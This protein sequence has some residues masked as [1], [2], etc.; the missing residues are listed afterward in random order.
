VRQNLGIAYGGGTPDAE[1]E[2]ARLFRESY[3]SFGRLVFEILYLLGPMKRFVR[4]AGDLRG[5]EHWDEAKRQ[6]RGVIFLSSHVGNWEVM[7]ATGAV[8][9]GMDILLVT[10]HLKPE[11]F[12]RAIEEG[13]RRCGVRATYEPRTFKD[14]L[15]HLKKNGTVGIV[16][17]QYSGPPVGVRVPVFGQP[18]GTST[19]VA[20]L[21]K[22]T[23]A[24]VLPVT[25]F[26]DG[27]KRVVQVEPPVEWVRN[28]DPNLELALNTAE[29]ARVLER[30]IR[31]H[32]E[33][34]LWIHRR[35]K[36]DLAPLRE[37]EWKAG[38]PRH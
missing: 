10:K 14:V 21:A 27:S 35:F 6:G 1:R 34:W 11:W 5:A 17:D 15:G 20:M 23:G 36:G 25:N 13:R 16:L 19:V 2:Q 18:V 37:G 31:S 12:H 3:A 33:E 32:P 28:D 24:V 8:H 38:R 22:R 7:A 26:K 4:H 30:H 9:G 29:Y